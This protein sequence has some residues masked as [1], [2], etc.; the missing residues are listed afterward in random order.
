M[1]SRK[2]DE[3]VGNP[4][5]W[6]FDGMIKDQTAGR[7]LFITENGYV[8]LGNV[9]ESDEIW[10]LFGGDLP[11]VLR[12]KPDTSSHLLLGDCFVHGIMYGEFMENLKKKTRAGRQMKSVILS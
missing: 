4:E 10:V 11:F 8:G 1:N 9:G 2:W 5:L 3:I 7:A 6:K 12:P